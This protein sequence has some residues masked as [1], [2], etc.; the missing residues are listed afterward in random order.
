[1]PDPHSANQPAKSGRQVVT[2]NDYLALAAFLQGS[3]SIQRVHKRV[4]NGEAVRTTAELY[5]NRE[6]VA[7]YECFKPA[8]DKVVGDMQRVLARNPGFE[9]NSLARKQQVSLVVAKERIQN[10]R[11]HAQQVMDQFE[12]LLYDLESKPLVRNHL[13]K[14]GSAIAAADPVEVEPPPTTVNSA[15][16]TQVDVVDAAPMEIVIGERRYTKAAYTPPEKGL[17]V[18]GSRQG[19]GRADHSGYRSEFGRRGG[20]TLRF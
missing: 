9:A 8:Y 11:V 10:I 1:M 4:P 6:Y 20:V 15:S 13:K 18:L 5:G 2:K 17:V 3:E 7:A 19:E 14:G 12:R 16:E